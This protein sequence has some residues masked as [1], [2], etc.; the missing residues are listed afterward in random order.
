MLTAAKITILSTHNRSSLKLCRCLLTNIKSRS[1][2]VFRLLS[3]P[4][5]NASMK[6]GVNATSIGAAHLAEV[7]EDLSV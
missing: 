4:G 3:V 5:Q 2:I 6:H 7:V 1:L